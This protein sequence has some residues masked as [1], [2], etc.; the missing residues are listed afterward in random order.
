[1]IRFYLIAF[2]VLLG[3]L[4]CCPAGAES[5]V[6]EA[7]TEAY[8][9]YCYRSIDRRTEALVAMEKNGSAETNERYIESI[10]HLVA[11]LIQVGLSERA[12]KEACFK[13][14]AEICAYEKSLLGRNS[15][16][17]SDVSERARVLLSVF[18]ATIAEEMPDVSASQDFRIACRFFTKR[19]DILAGLAPSKGN[20]LAVNQSLSSQFRQ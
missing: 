6:P 5:G 19:A 20:R 18:E 17:Q 11:A 16:V 3:L 12:K 1:M 7:S 10:H 15:K 14:A 8:L 9:A 13:Q 4:A 2:F